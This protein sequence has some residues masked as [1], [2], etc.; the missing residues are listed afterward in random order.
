MH[1]LIHRMGESATFN[2]EKSVPSASPTCR[3]AG[4]SRSA[5]AKRSIAVIEDHNF[6]KYNL[7]ALLWRVKNKCRQKREHHALS[8]AKVGQT[9]MGRVLPAAQRAEP[10]M[11]AKVGGQPN[12]DWYSEF[13]N[14]CLSLT[15]SPYRDATNRTPHPR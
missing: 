2:S 14:S 1:S 8:N 9:A 4:L 13:I 3:N 10:A 15:M 12:I 5:Y 7:R 11:V 6:T